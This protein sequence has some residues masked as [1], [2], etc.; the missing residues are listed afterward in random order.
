[1]L[2]SSSAFPS[3]GCYIWECGCATSLLGATFG[4]ADV[5]LLCWVL[6]LDVRMCHFWVGRAGHPCCQPFALFLHEGVQESEGVGGRAHVYVRVRGCACGFVHDRGL[7]AYTRGRVVLGLL[8]CCAGMGIKEGKEARA[9]LWAV[10]FMRIPFHTLAW[11]MIIHHFLCQL[12]H[13]L[14]MFPRACWDRVSS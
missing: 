12:Q 11:I 8:T 3:A 1:M 7:C 5:P 6:H 9:F 2:A 4:S 14:H 13:I 10:E